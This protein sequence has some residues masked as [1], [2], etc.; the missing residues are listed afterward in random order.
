MTFQGEL[1]QERA[2]LQAWALEHPDRAASLADWYRQLR[3]KVAREDVNEFVEL[4]MKDELTGDPVKQAPVH[5]EFQRLA[6]AHKRLVIWSH[7]ESGKTSQLTV[8]RTLW[9]L[10]RNPNMRIAIV[11]NTVRQAMKI[12]RAIGQYIERPGIIHEVFPN[13]RPG[14]KWG[15]MA[16]SIE[17]KS[18]AKDPS[19]QACGT[20]VG[21][22][23]G[24]RLDG[25]ILDDVLTYENTLM[26]NRRNALWDWYHSTLAGRMTE[27]AFV[28][29]VGTAF[30]PD[31]LLH[32]LAKNPS[33]Q[34]ARFPVV[35]EGTGRSNWTERW[36]DKRIAAKKIELGPHE[37][38]R[39]MLCIARDD[40]ESR[41]KREWIDQCL[42]R[43]EG[44]TPAFALTTI[45]AGYAT[46]TGVDLG[47]RVR[48]GADLTVLFTI[49]VH[50]NGDRE[51]LCVESGRWAAKE[52]VNRIVDTHKRF[53]SIITVENNA[54]QQ[55]IVDFTKATSAVP[56]RPFNTGKNKYHPE[57]GIE[58]IAT[59]MSNGKWI[60]PA[61]NGMPAT[62]E[63]DKW[64]GELLYYDPKSHPGDR[65]MA[66]W[67]ARE[68]S[69]FTK[70]RGQVGRVNTLSR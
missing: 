55:F 21:T 30:N 22:I 56:V 47:V 25:A 65:L 7:I 27:D 54:A 50:P 64:I 61:V 10:G 19:V 1:A 67:F 36:S 49:C 59:E 44:K 18:N 53:H 31:D 16:F 14:A 51:V 29:V 4:V 46:Y 32:R 57:F 34:Y 33:F 63:I 6:S 24:A 28:R 26:P 60:I 35:N 41:F 42:A 37:F 17:R 38:A 66:S 13:L 12:V 69:R 39:Q 5:L 8:A 43:G 52:I 48:D 40:G 68:G 23:L 11:S 45:P 58:S 62:T 2:Q 15:G 9:D 20:N 70:P 3:I